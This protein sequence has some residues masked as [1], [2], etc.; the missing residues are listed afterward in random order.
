MPKPLE[1]LDQP[2]PAADPFLGWCLKCRQPT[3]SNRRDFCQADECQDEAADNFG[4]CYHCHDG[5]HDLCIEGPCQCPCPTP[6][7]RC[8][9]EL[10]ASAAAKLTPE[11]RAALGI[12]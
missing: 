1:C 12:I 8:L 4:R 10:R 3:G 2:K 5:D 7:Q 9:A 6:D 11:E